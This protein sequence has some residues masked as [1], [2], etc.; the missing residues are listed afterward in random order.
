M[1]NKHN[2]ISTTHTVG[3]LYAVDMGS[4]Q[5]FY[6][7]NT[8][9]AMLLQSFYGTVKLLY[10]DTTTQSHWSSGSTVC[11]PPRGAS[12]RAPRV[13]LHFWNWDLLLTM[14][15]YIGDPNVIPDHQP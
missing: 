13:H 8:Y 2:K 7:L 14:S 4:A 3:M 10:S 11:F 6:G 5:Y 15:C 1:L 12:V 9:N